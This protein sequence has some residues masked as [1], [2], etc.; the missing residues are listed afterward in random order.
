VSPPAALVAALRAA[1]AEAFDP[2]GFGF[3][4]SLLAR[5]EALGGGARARLLDR[6]HGR[7]DALS[8]A[9]HEARAA[10]ERELGALATDDAA[11]APALREAL[12]RGE[13]A[14]VRREI[15]RALRDRG[16]E[17]ERVPV[18]WLTRLRAAALARGSRL[19]DAVTREL[20]AVG[21]D[22]GSVDRSAHTRAVAAGEALSRALFQESAESARALIAVAHATDDVPDDAG[23]YNGRVLASRALAVMAGLSPE[24]V[25]V[26]VAVADDLAALEASLAP[27]AATARGTK[28]KAA[29]RRRVQPA[30]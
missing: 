29:K 4:E 3:I 25:R 21:A 10:A 28:A 11:M 22:D 18:P 8:A 17:R 9:L 1:G 6:A 7:I 27:E 19:P 30:P 5:A 14:R 15:R 20:D 23:P 12:A 2:L 24:Y 16:R 26:V 13:V